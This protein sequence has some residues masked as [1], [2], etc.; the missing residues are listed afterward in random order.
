MVAAATARAYAAACT[1]NQTLA[2]NQ[3]IV[4]LQRQTLGVTQRLFRGGRGTAFDVTR[5]QAAVEQSQAQTPPIIAS[6]QAALYE[7]GALLGGPPENYPREL[8][9]CAASPRLS[10]P[11]PIGD[12][13][14]L[15]RRRPDMRAAERSL[16]AATARIGVATAD[17]YPQVSLGGSLGLSGPLAGIGRGSD[18]NISLG[19]LVSWSF[20]DRTATRARIAEAGATA[21][22]AAA[23]YDATAIEALRQVETALSAYARELDRNRALRLARDSAARATD[24]AA[25][26]F[27]FG[28]AGF[29]DVL[30]AQANLAVA[31]AT[32]AT[33]DAIVIDRQIDV[34]LALGG[35]WT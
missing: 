5:A 9:S 12:G 30:T 17:M 7:L 20:P 6:R 33:S 31:E 13:S 10:R 27:R 24:Q 28:R 26:L 29:L 1:A 34:F 8:E 23:Q 3:R 14:A 11:I 32:L 4:A 18:L 21:E 35:G 22:A 19:P 15:L 16:A 25:R 2:A